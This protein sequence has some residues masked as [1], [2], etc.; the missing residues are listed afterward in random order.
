MASSSSATSTVQPP[1]IITSSFGASSNPISS[2]ASSDTDDTDS[3][4]SIRLAPRPRLSGRMSSGTNIVPRDHPN[5]EMRDEKFAANDAR[6]MSPRRT[7][8]E[9]EKLG[10][11]TRRSLQMHARTLQSGL[12]ALAEKIEIVKSDH[13]KLEKQNLALQDYIGGLTRSMSR[14]DLTSKSKK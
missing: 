3:D 10:E 8:L 12:N 7:S 14:T 5:I 2:N 13:E 6:A 11:D 1:N 4:R 9:T